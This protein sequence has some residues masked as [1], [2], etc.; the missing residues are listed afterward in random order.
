[1]KQVLFFILATLFVHF[2][3]SSE[4]TRFKPDWCS[5]NQILASNI[6]V[7]CY[8]EAQLRDAGSTRA[9]ALKWRDGTRD[10]FIESDF[11]TIDM[12]NLDVTILGPVASSKPRNKFAPKYTGRMQLDIDSDG[13]VSSV[14][15]MLQTG[16]RF[17]S[18]RQ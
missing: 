2:A 11:T 17:F 8:G 5:A 10:L 6:K 13:E 18:V 3:E 12:F 16:E 15:G 4:I 9:V 14:Q 1:M 7:V